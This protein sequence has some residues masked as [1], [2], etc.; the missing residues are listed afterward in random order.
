[1]RQ[2]HIMVT[3]IGDKERLNTEAPFQSC[4]SYTCQM[5]SVKVCQGKYGVLGSLGSKA[6]CT[7]FIGKR[8]NKIEKVEDADQ[9]RS[10]ATLH[11]LRFTV[12]QIFLDHP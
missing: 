10:T 1:M 4:S 5:Y 2:A 6:R 12:T 3:D 7:Y 9:G 11:Y 8:D